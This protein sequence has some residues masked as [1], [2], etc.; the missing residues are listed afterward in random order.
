MKNIHIKQHESTL[1]LKFVSYPKTVHKLFVKN[2]LDSIVYFSVSEQQPEFKIDLNE[3]IN[4]FKPYG[5]QKL[6]LIIEES[7]AIL[8]TQRTLS[9]VK[10]D[11]VVSDLNPIQQQAL[12]LT[13]YLTKNGYF[14]FA[15]SDQPVANQFLT[16]RHI[17]KLKFSNEQAL[18]AGQFTIQNC[19]FKSAKLHIKSRFSSHIT[20]VT[21]PT[22]LVQH[23]NKTRRAKYNFNI[24]IYEQLIAFMKHD[25]E[26]E[27]VIDLFLAVDVKE[28]LQPITVKLGNP[29]IAVEYLL[30]GEII[31]SYQH[32]IR[33]ITP[34]FTLKGRNLSFRMN[35][36]DVESYQTYL[37][38]L[39]HIGY[40]KPKHNVWVIGEKAYKAQ[41][42]GYHFFK[43][44]RTAHPELEV[45]YVIHKDSK[46]REHVLPYGNVIDFGSAEH[47]KVMLEANYI[48]TTHHPEL[49]YPTTS[50]LY[51]QHI[52]ATK[53]FLQHGVLGTKN[54]SDINGNQL[55]D[56]NVDVFITSSDRE[57]EIVVRDLKFEESQVKVTGLARFD[58]L[59]V[60]NVKIKNQV[61]IIPTWRDW[62]TNVDQL[63][64][65]EYLKRMNQ[66]LNSPMIKYYTEQGIDF[67]FCLHPNMQPF[68][69]YFD[70]PDYVTRVKQGDIDVQQLIKESKLMITDYS[71]VAFDFSFL[72]KPVIYYQYDKERFLGKQPS[73]LD[74]ENELPGV[75]V[76][77]Q[78]DLE[79]QLSHYIKHHYKVSTEIQ[80]RARNFYQYQD[81]HNSE[82]IFND[83]VAYQGTPFS[84][85]LKHSVL[86]QHFYNRFKK[87]SYY[88]NVMKLYNQM[89]TK[90][91]VDQD[92][93][94]FES[95][96]GKSVSDSPKAIY[97]IL[98][99]RNHHFK[100][101]WVT[102]NSYPFNDNRVI[103]VKRLSPEYFYYLSHA[104][105]WVNNQNFPTYMKKNKET[106][107]IQT[108]H[109]TPLKKMLN[110]VDKFEGRTDDY[111]ER[112]NQ[113]IQ[114]W[115]Y[116][117]SPSPYATNCFKSAFNFHKEILEVGYP[118][119]DIF[120]SKDI[121]GIETK[122][123]TVRQQLGISKDKKV[124]LYAPTFRDDETNKAKKHII[125]LKLD[126]HKLKARLGEDY[127]IL[128]RPHI[129][130]SNALHLDASLADFAINVGK[131]NEISDL[132]LI[133]DICITDYSSVMFD[134]A[135][136]KRPLLF[137]TY[138]L[139]HYKNDLRGFY[140]DFEQEAPGPLLQDNESLIQAIENIGE[141]QDSYQDKYEAFYNKFCTYE[142]GHAAE[143]IV[144]KF[145]K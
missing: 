144:D 22:K 17:D 2:E 118:R 18:I 39:K 114:T 61:V 49:I 141:V 107:Y 126:L 41:D 5:N 19:R 145:F 32:Q 38:A 120:Y 27:D 117:V 99:Q 64:Q 94:V 86:A 36:Y 10:E 83:I 98:K 92:L 143:Q 9:I 29:R 4:R 23:D 74:I 87:N 72:N 51:T 42:N 112:V 34:Y 84:S 6:Y 70:V 88:P 89:M 71:S 25:F 97:D 21:L 54:L 24:D 73:H 93:I 77:N 40:T 130:V 76:N 35:T 131:Y 102:N 80:K 113:A 57:K 37:D 91:S 100:I 33:S 95:N 62:L 110:D 124:I 101:V 119:N 121:E 59:F 96:I 132:Y 69:E 90:A 133:T 128:L 58:E 116:L 104:K 129:I 135:N 115:D 44:M 106:I 45:Y 109:G 81:R 136:T 14:S 28:S 79:R 78:Q 75:I 105:Y 122:K 85:K 108:W 47:F 127:V 1:V 16:H 55:K 123:Q 46:E 68:I 125:N 66:L 56:F 142:T 13:P 8:T 43:Y 134:F 11:T 65:S 50:R 60:D 140:F 7:D 3:I 52:T 30:K 139:E 137:F 31:T 67:M 53:V 82:R 138:D 103:T 15:L 20:E 111:K 63:Q 48:C 12:T 26:Q